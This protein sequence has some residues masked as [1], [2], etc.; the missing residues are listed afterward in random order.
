MFIVSILLILY[1]FFSFNMNLLN[2]LPDVS[3]KDKASVAL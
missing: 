2:L 1:I 3:P